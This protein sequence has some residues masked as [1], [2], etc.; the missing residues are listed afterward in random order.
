M[1]AKIYFLSDYCDVM[2][3]TMKNDENLPSNYILL[4][5]NEITHIFFQN[6]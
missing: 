3:V 2:F 5:K 1:L 6:W 4:L